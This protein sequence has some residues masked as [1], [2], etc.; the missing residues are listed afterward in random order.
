V[1]F[2]N[3]YYAL[4][5][6]PWWLIFL[7]FHGTLIISY[8]AEQTLL[9]RVRRSME[10]HT[11]AIGCDEKSRVVLLIL[12][13]LIIVFSFRAGRWLVTYPRNWTTISIGVAMA[14]SGTAMRLFSLAALGA[15]FRYISR[16][17][18]SHKLVTRGPYRILRHPMYTGLFLFFIGLSLI[19]CEAF[20]CLGYMAVLV[21]GAVRRIPMEE[22]ML[23]ERFGDEFEAYR[24]RTWKLIPFVY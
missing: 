21:P 3:E 10:G 6:Q 13:V 9:R 20:I 8:L 23:E 15:N 12:G 17:T 19:L 11:D 2:L 24:A 1:S 4:L 7:L 18:D 5:P 14:L 22:R 16:M